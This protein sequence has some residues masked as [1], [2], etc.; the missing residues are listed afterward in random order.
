MC[1]I[2]I[3]KKGLPLPKEEHLRNGATANADGLGIMYHKLGAAMVQVKKDFKN[4]DELLTFQKATIKKDD[5]AVI[6]FR[7]ATHGLKD[8][9]NRHPFPVTLNREM[10]R[11][12]ETACQMAMAHN[13]IIDQYSR[14]TPQKYSDTQKFILDILAQERIKS[15]L[16][17]EAIKKL[18]LH[19]IGNDKLVIL[20]NRGGLLLF[21]D[22]V[23][24]G[25]ILFSN[26][27][28][29]TRYAGYSWEP[30]SWRAWGQKTKAEADFQTCAYCG[31]FKR[32]TALEID[33]GNENLEVS[34]CKTCR[35]RIRKK[36]L[37]PQ[38]FIY[39]GEMQEDICDFC[40][41]LFPEIEL[42]DAPD[43]YRLCG[44]CYPRVYGDKEGGG[45][46]AT[47]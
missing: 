8:I 16:N 19:Y 42:K 20:D 27:S 5:T 1:L 3:K 22:F 2:V 28:Y 25:G 34:A 46:Y 18:I 15:G 33:T 44:E 21:N 12:G 4:I 6:H 40:D 43:G 45:I 37:D 31:K 14:L 39:S 26:T 32:V 11:A 9:G 35:K 23:D 17:D 29:L 38:S 47:T 7:L 30:Q 13:G 24:E 41:Q 10:L 36:K